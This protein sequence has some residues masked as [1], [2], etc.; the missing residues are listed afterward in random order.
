[1]V[2]VVEQ[3]WRYSSTSLVPWEMLSSALR[4]LLE[5]RLLALSGQS[6]HSGPEWP[7][8]GHQWTIAKKS[9]NHINKLNKYDSYGVLSALQTPQSNP[10]HIYNIQRV[11]FVLDDTGIQKSP[12]SGVKKDPI[13]GQ[14]WP[15][16]AVFDHILVVF[17]QKMVENFTD[18]APRSMEIVPE[19]FLTI[20][21]KK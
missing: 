11:L 17:G 4:V 9:S 2:S 13:L 12:N 19:W 16:M 21:A 1:M 14:N 18:Q 7:K 6:G 10:V 15:K 3:K 20:V 5:L 8:S